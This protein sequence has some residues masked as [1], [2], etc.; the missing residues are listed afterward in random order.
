MS[1][2]RLGRIGGIGFFSFANILVCSGLVYYVKYY[3]GET[4]AIA[5]TALTMGSP[6]RPLTL[7]P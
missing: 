6:G 5:S 3:L 4:E 1:R 2:R 7:I